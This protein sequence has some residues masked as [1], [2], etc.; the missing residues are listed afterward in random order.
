MTDDTEA[1]ANRAA[2]AARD[3]VKAQSRPRGSLIPLIAVAFAILSGIYLFLMEGENPP[4]ATT[5]M[6]VPHVQAPGEGTASTP[7]PTTPAPQQ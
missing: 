3:A 4:R 5:P 2:I 7:R 1:A 6:P